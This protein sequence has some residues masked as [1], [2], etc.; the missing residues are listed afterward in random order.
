VDV[1]KKPDEASAS[2]HTAEPGAGTSHETDPRGSFRV[3]TQPRGIGAALRDYT[4]RLRS[5]DPG[6]L[7]AVLGLLVLGV[8]FAA[9]TTD[10]LS[11]L[12]IANLTSQASYISLISLGLVF[13][14]LI[15]EI[16]LSA[17]T[18][19]GLCA[20]FAAQALQSDSL[21]G[22]IGNIVFVVL[23]I[24]LI[25][26]LALG[27][28]NGMRTAPAFSL[29]GLILLFTTL[30]H[31]NTALAF[32]FAICIGVSIG[33][34]SGVL[35][36]RL[37]IPS[38]IVTLA[39]FL[40]WEG[41][42]L[43]VLNNQSI[44][45][46]NYSFWFGLTHGSMSIWAGWLLF[47]LLA[48]GYLVFTFIRSRLRA[49]AGLSH[50]TYALVFLRGGAVVVLGAFV[51]W[52]F[53]Q[54]RSS[55]SLVKIEGVPWAA[56]VPIL[57][58]VFWSLVLSKSTWGRHLYAIGG[59]AE[60]ARRAGIP[61]DRVR[62]SAFSICSGMA[63][64]GGFFLADISGGAT[65]GLGQGDILLF[66]VAATVIGGTSLF[67]GRGKPRDAIIGALVIAMIPNGIHLHEFPEQANEVITGAV[68][69][70]AASVDA[71]SRRR[72]K[73]H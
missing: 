7:P 22:A 38:F 63:A 66:A 24:G 37:G 48:G 17:G 18:T 29:L 26:G 73:A 6:A 25:A 35:V 3:D 34:I 47:I 44:S 21:H 60:A 12:N 70:V 72:S 40:A 41:V 62:I 8:I 54:N 10:F 65:T 57:F 51:T 42:E 71:I 11:K 13:V 31:S 28:L 4:S 30:E 14:L 36:S 2:S 68:L 32:L 56:M 49:R 15:G 64:V 61:V 27:V 50:D 20:A 23:I 55:S 5:G 53:S 46:T 58:M 59:N 52:F 19:G 39:L 69:L 33:T 67:G 16:D 1:T 45:T 43:F 9:T